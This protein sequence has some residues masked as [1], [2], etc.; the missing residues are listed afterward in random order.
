MYFLCNTKY[1]I[2]GMRFM[3]ITENGND[4]NRFHYEF[5]FYI[6]SKYMIFKYCIRIMRITTDNNNYTFNK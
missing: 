2:T 4:F 5:S 3:I 6:I 1:C